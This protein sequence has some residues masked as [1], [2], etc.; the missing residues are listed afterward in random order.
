MAREPQIAI[1]SLRGGMRDSD[2]P[3]ILADDEAVLAEHVEFFF[4]TLGERRLGC[5]TVDI[6]DAGLSDE[7]AIVHLAIHMPKVAEAEALDH[8]LFAIGATPNTSTSVALRDAAGVWTAIIPVD[9]IDVSDPE[10]FRMHSTS[11]HGKWFLTYK[12]SGDRMH[13]WDGTTL[14][15]AGLAQ[16]AAAPTAANAGV[17]TFAETRFYRI[18]YVTQD[19]DSITILRSEPSE[20]LE[21]TPSGTGASVTVTRPALIG[22]VETHWEIEAS[23]G[24]GNWYMLATI[25]KATTTYSDT[26]NPPSDYAI[27]GELSADIGDYALIP[28]A[29]FVVRDQDRVIFG[30]HWDDPER[31]SRVYWTPPSAATGVGNDERIPVDTDNFLDLDWMDSGELTGLS[32]PLN[33]QFYA[34]KINR[35]YKLQRTGNVDG[36]YEAFLISTQR[37]AVPGSII[38]GTDEYGRGCVYFLD[39]A[40]GPLRISTGGIQYCQGLQGTWKR[41]NTGASQITAH[42]VYYP[43]KQQIHWWV[44]VDGGDKPELRVLLQ[45]DEIRSDNEGTTRGW[46]IATGKSS[47][48]WCS[49]IVPETVLDEESGSTSLTYRPYIGLPGPFFIQRMDSGRTDAGEEYI[50]KIVTKPY[51]VTGLLNKWGAMTAALLAEPHD[52]PEMKLNI[53]FIRDFGL[54][55]NAVVT[56]F[57]PKDSESLV[58]KPFDNLR[59]SGAIAIQVEFSDHEPAFDV[60][61]SEP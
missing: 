36:A 51:F 43:D 54:E 7:T 53:K 42:G 15:R 9:T 3:H 38:S 41:A 21:F 4:T 1:S 23:D 22:E 17:G 47:E 49:A 20:E 32:D 14:R 25:L 30:S 46:A 29:K 5:E 60:P 8:Q 48:A 37:G 35:V 19:A 44:A 57:I 18:R 59:M 61:H 12:A 2:P 39:P 50:A 26:I 28:S 56:N 40:V 33:G 10:I 13:L 27:N 58:I 6:T 24:D 16:P 45:V 11:I 52:D 34:F 31:G 55:E